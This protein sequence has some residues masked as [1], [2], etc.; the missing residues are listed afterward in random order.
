MDKQEFIKKIGLYARQWIF[1]ANPPA[2][3]TYVKKNQRNPE[4]FS[5]KYVAKRA[6]EENN[7]TGPIQIISWQKRLEFCLDCCRSV[8][9]RVQVIDLERSQTKCSCGLKYPN[10]LTKKSD[11]V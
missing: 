11:C 2:K 9:D 1:D 3:G 6:I 5:Q 8:E 7:A 10:K 4:D